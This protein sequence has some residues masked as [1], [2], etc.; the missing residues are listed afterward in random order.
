MIVG[1]SDTLSIEDPRVALTTEGMTNSRRESIMNLSTRNRENYYA[2]LKSLE[3]RVKK[4]QWI[5]SGRP[6]FCWACEEPMPMNMRGFNFHHRTYDNLGNENLDDLVLLCSSDHRR[7]SEE[8]EPMKIH[9]MSLADW[10]WAYIALTRG[11]LG[12]KKINESKIAKYLG[13]Y[14]D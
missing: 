14:N 8:Y 4:N 13:E 12:L 6:T 10:T 3:W 1:G 9:G 11:E 2:Y 7:L 5:D